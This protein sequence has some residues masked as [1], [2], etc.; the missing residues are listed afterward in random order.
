MTLRQA[1]LAAVVVIA[2]WW[3]AEA[4]LWVVVFH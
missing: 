4:I 3:G 2:I 1:L